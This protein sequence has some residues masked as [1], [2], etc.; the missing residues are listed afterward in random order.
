MESWPCDVGLGDLNNTSTIQIQVQVQGLELAHPKPY[1]IYELLE[2]MKEPC[3]IDQC[4]KITMTQGSNGI[5]QWRS[6]MR[7]VEEAKGLEPTIDSLQWLFASK[8]IET[9]G[10]IRG[11][12]RHTTASTRR[13]FLMF[14]SLLKLLLSIFFCVCSCECGGVGCKF[15]G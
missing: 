13:F 12:Q 11:T 10:Y 5:S 7:T 2:H 3:P 4:C 14:C 9:K 15:R 8:D 6:S 1:H